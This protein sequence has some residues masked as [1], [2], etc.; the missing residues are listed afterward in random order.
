MRKIAKRLVVVIMLVSLLSV[1]ITGCS[2]PQ[3]STSGNESIEPKVEKQFLRIG[4]A[5]M[6][7]NFFP[8]ASALAQMINEKIEN[9]NA[10][11][12]AT[13]GS[14]ENCNFIGQGEV[15]LALVQSA[16][17][18]EA[19]E[20]F[21]GFE[22]RPIEN[23]RGITAIYFNE[24]HILVRND[25]GI[26]TVEDLRGK[27][28]A[29]GPIGGGIEVNTN[30]I[31]AAHGISPEDYTAVYGTRAEATEGLKTGGVDCHIYATGIGS[32]QIAELMLTDKIKLLPITSDKIELLT[33]DN[34]EFGA[35][36]IPAATYKNQDEELS[37]IAG[38][39]LFIA[40]SELSEDTV[41][42]ITKAIFEDLEYLQTFHN[43]FTQTRPETAR[44]GMAVPL[45][46]GAEKYFKE[47]GILD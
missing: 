12:Q 19:Y 26:N 6:G 45:H 35:S 7:G 18:R 29:V 25:A 40:S 10:S 47:V 9:V 22:G 16:T 11:A 21:G 41:Y 38:S 14:A 24:F 39:S 2:Q 33:K 32:A 34:P 13:G 30:Q 3:P 27:K 20:G 5:S 4:S 1:I 37:T 31:L 23:M 28:I 42:E 44:S 8:L 36:V 17:L 15:E 43:Y 46:P